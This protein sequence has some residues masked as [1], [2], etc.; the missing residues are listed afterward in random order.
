MWVDS[1]ATTVEGVKKPLNLLVSTSFIYMILGVLS[2]LFYR[3]FSKANGFPDGGAP[4]QLG[5]TH[6]HLL[7]L[8]F[9]AFLT[10]L[11]LEKLFTISR[12]R[13]L[14]AWFFWLYNV[15]VVLTAG[16]QIWHGMLTITGGTA[17]GM[18]SGMAGLGHIALTAGLIVFFVALRR[19]IAAPSPAVQS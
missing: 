4:G 2:G 7:A 14:F 9:F 10:F 3:E 19:S 5:L 15:G 6:T 18:I 13:K 1:N 11:A 16:M 12:N 8:G 17:S